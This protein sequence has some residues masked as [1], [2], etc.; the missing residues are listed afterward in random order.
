MLGRVYV[1]LDSKYV[2]DR[3]MV[4]ICEKV[5][6]GG[7]ELL[8]LR[9]K[10]WSKQKIYEVAREIYPI[11]RDFNVPLIINDFP[12][13]GKEFDG[14]HVGKGDYNMENFNM[15]KGNGIIGVSCYN[16]INLSLKL[17]DKKVSYVAFSSPYP[18]TTK[19]K[20]STTFS[21]FERAK[22]VLRIPFYAIGGIDEKRAKEVIS[23]GA[24][25]VAVISAV[26]TSEDPE[27]ATRRIKDAVYS[28]L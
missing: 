12:D 13:M 6:K 15:L 5:L 26:L 18:S 3:E 25:G 21:L 16:D 22:E 7:A 11:C 19:E 28:S 8:Q 17:Q 10:D 1:I 20:E 9:A 2:S 27:D 24:Y 23:H 4:A 14:V